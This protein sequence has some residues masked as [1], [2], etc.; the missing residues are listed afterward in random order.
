[1]AVEYSSFGVHLTSLFNIVH[2]TITRFFKFY[3]FVPLYHNYINRKI[4]KIVLRNTDGLYE[5]YS[6]RNFESVTRGN[7]SVIFLLH[8]LIME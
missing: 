4:E 3:I 8:S 6:N 7:L 2:S 1:M 5:L